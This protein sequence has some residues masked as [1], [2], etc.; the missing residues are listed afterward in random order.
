MV[1]D[2]QLTV[3]A[4]SISA[5]ALTVLLLFFLLVIPRLSLVLPAAAIDKKCSFKESWRLTKN[6]E[7]LM[8][9]AVFL[10]PFVFSFPILLL[11]N[12]PFTM[13]VSIVL[14]TFVEILVIAAL[15]ISYK[16]ISQNAKL[17]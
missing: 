6:R 8:F 3:V 5:F 17:A 9:Y 14:M 11:S 2:E 4:I 13:V 15:S 12:I 7:V 1:K 16:V 10:I